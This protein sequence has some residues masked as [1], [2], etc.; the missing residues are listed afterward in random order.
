MSASFTLQE[1]IDRASALLT[2]ER[3]GK[4]AFD[5][6]MQIFSEIEVDAGYLD[7][8]RNIAET[9]FSDALQAIQDLQNVL[10]GKYPHA[11]QNTQTNPNRRTS[12]PKYISFPKIGIGPSERGGR[13]V[14]ALEPIAAHEVI[15]IVPVIICNKSLIGQTSLRDYYF[16][17]DST[18]ADECAIALGYGSMYN[19]EDT[20]SA[21]W[22][23]D[24]VGREIAFI[25]NHDIGVEEEITIS[26]GIDYWN[27]TK[28]R[29]TKKKV[30]TI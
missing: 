10:D 26:Y 11:S 17:I 6:V 30:R 15:E 8:R 20:P 25:A 29:G 22:I 27:D 28:R 4:P 21:H 7:D 18:G 19:H 14:Y 9:H 3:V 1:Y 5:G 16:G 12:I 13:G 24:P 23:V 2:A